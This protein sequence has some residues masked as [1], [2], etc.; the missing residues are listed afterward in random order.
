[1][2]FFL[3]EDFFMYNDDN[4]LCF[5]IKK[6]GYKVYFY[7]TDVIH[8]GGAT[9]LKLGKTVGKNPQIEK[10]QI[11]SQAIYF[12]KNYGLGIVLSNLL[13]IFIYDFLKA[14]KDAFRFRKTPS[15]SERFSHMRQV[16]SINMKTGFG[17]KSIH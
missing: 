5:R 6:M 8:L 17:Q 15:M 9:A 10:W 4:D 16:V 7:P 3:R 2:G 1:M 13:F 12:R 11:E 14:V